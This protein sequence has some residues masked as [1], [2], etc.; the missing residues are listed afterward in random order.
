MS[1]GFMGVTPNTYGCPTSVGFSNA[2]GLVGSFAEQA[3]RNQDSF[4]GTQRLQ[5]APAPPP[6]QFEL[7][8]GP[9][10]NSAKLNQEMRDMHARWFKESEEYHEKHFGLRK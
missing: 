6:P 7:Y 2:I 4:N 3:H 9:P 1:R 8:K 5:F 10:D